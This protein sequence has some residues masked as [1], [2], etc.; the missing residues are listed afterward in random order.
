MNNAFTIEWLLVE[1]QDDLVGD[2]VVN[3]FCSHGC[4]IT[5][6]IHLY[7]CRPVRQ[8][9]RPCP[10]CVA[11]EIDGDIDFKIVQQTCSMTVTGEP[12]VMKSIERLEQARMN[13]AALVGSK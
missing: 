11:L 1:R 2:Y 9:A 13:I 12:N 3:E 8:N 7:G 5:E 6:V 4:R 10:A